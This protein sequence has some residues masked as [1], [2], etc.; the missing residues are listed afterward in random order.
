MTIE[1]IKKKYGFT[2]KPQSFSFDSQQVTIQ[3]TQPKND[4]PFKNLANTE[5]FR[6][7]G[8]KMSVDIGKPNYSDIGK[9]NF[10]DI[11]SKYQHKR[12]SFSGTIGHG[13][14]N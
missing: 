9:S 4:T 5:R 1:G 6:E 2:S 13:S 14:N 7:L 12:P 8:N 11:K 10:S 3:P